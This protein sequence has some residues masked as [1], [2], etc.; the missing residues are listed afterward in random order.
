MVKVLLVDDD[1]E[2]LE[3]LRDTLQ[4]RNFHCLLAHSGTEALATL[5]KEDIEL[6]LTDINMPKM[7]GIELLREVSRKWPS[8]L[9]M[10]MTG[11]ADLETTI[12]AIN[13]GQI[14]AYFTKPWDAQLLLEKI[15]TMLKEKHSREKEE[16]DTTRY[17]DLVRLERQQAMNILNSF[18]ELST[19]A[20]IMVDANGKTTYWNTT[21]EEIFGYRKDE[22]LGEDFHERICPHSARDQVRASLDLLRESGQCSWMNKRSELQAR[23]KDGREIP[24]ELTLRPLEI[25]GK[26]VALGVI[27]DISERRQ[28]ENEKQRSFEKFQRSLIQTIRAIGLTVEKRD[29]YTAGHQS[30]V[31]QL[32]TGIANK[33]ALPEEQVKGIELGAT[34]HDIGKIY[35]PAEI[36]NRPGRLSH[37]EFEMIK[38]HPEV[39]FDIVREV[40]FPWP[41]AA[42]IRQHHER[43]DGSG[44]P[45]GLQG[46]AIILEAQIIAVA[47]V[48]EAIS[49]HRPYR[50][51]LSIDTGLEEIASHKVSKY[52]PA[53]VDACLKVFKEDNFK[54]EG[55]TL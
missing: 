53:A 32:A 46:D 10:I 14:H 34:I 8:V 27:S 30:R 3:V 20:V 11:R 44:Y 1:P 17:I 9:R 12:E 24:V 55:I 42:M 52:N 37:A 43:L 15:S 13:R 31:A 45:G 21:A 49:S 51:A 28:A 19:D 48:V 41:V 26:W 35:I 36:L 25:N 7:N 39:G 16:Q 50:P 5:G 38:T 23:H 22:I 54:F 18:T 29:P 2:I 33:M 40:E 4:L 6:V 47:D